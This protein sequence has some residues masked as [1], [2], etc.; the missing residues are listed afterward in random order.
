[1]SEKRIIY[2][3]NAATTPLKKVALD[4]MMPYLTEQFGNPSGIYSYSKNAKNA[5]DESRAKI[6]NAINAAEP[7]EILFTGSG[8]EGDNWAFK[9]IADIKKKKGKHIITSAIEHHAIIHTCDWLKTKGYDITYIPV[10]KYGRVDPKDVEAAIR[11]DTILISIIMANNEI[12]TIEPIAE[13]GIIA[14]THKILFHTDA[15][16]AA[17]HIPIDVQA[18]NVDLLTI[19]GHKFGG[20]KG[21]GVLYI[22]KGIRLTPLIHGGQQERN[23]RGGTENVAG[24]VGLAVALED[25]VK[26]MQEN[27]IKIRTIS[28]KVITGLLKIPYTQ[29]TGDPINRLPGTA[30]FTFNFI[31]GESIMLML[32]LNGICASSGSACSSGSLDPSHVLMA[33]GLPH[34]IAHGSV[35]LTFNEQN[36]EADADYIIE[37]IPTI[38]DKLREMSPVWEDHLKESKKKIVMV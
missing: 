3:D 19:S 6:A 14:K 11:S 4:A 33:I 23:M 28:K 37:K 22:K 1:M 12:G 34:E 8:S 16:Q 7:S 18:L 13:I 29:L 9:G 25:S 35:R 2:A 27:T 17:G 15:V 21:I 32:N 38:I 31:E 26:H 24:I 30:S 20:P 36:T 5:I 10:D